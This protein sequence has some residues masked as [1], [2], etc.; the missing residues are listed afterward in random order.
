MIMDRRDKRVPTYDLEGLKAAARHGEIT[1]TVTARTSMYRLGGQ[2]GD[3]INLI[4]SLDRSM[5]YKSMPSLADHSIWQDVY[6]PPW[7]GTFLY[8]KIT[9]D[10]RGHVVLSFKEKD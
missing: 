6:H 9:V 5:F 10:E 2:D 4:L 1:M 7:R 3:E 8:F